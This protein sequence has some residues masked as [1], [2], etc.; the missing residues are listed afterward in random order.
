[1]EKKYKNVFWFLIDGLRPDFLHLDADSETCNFIDK[2]LLKGTVFN[3]VVTA[4]GGTFTSMHSIF[5]SLLPSFNGV[6]GWEK[7]AL[8]NFNEEIFTITDYFQ[9]AGYETFRYDDA[10]LSRDCPMNGFK[11]W[12]GSG[13]QT[14]KILDHTDLTKTERRNRFIEDVNTYAAN[15]FVYHHIALLHDL[16]GRMG[17][18]WTSEGYARD[19]KVT[20]KEFE[21]LYHEYVISEED[22]VIISADHGVLLD[23][24]YVHDNRKNKGRQYE[25]SVVSFFALI[26]QNVP[27]QILSNPISALDEAPTLLH[28]ALE[29][30][31][32]GQGRD[33]YNYIYKGE[34]QKAIYFR[35]T[36][37]LWG[38]PGLEN[39]L[40]SDLYYL[41]DGKWKY[42]YGDRDPRC[43]W[44]I[45][46]EED[47]DYQVNRKDQY[48][49]LR[50]K[51]YQM[52]RSKFDAAKDFQYRPAPGLNK[53]DLKKEF[54][55]I[56][57]VDD[58]DVDTVESVLDMSG[59]YYE[60]IMTRSDVTERFKDHYKVHL[61]DTLNEPAI[62]NCCQGEWLV[63]LSKNGEYSEYFLS[64]LYRYIQH[65]RKTNVKIIGEHYI[66]V[67]R[68]EAENFN[69]VELYETKQVRTIR[70]VHDEA[71]KFKYILFGCGEVGKEAVD[72][73][74]QANV[75]C[76]VDNNPTL[77][78]KD[79]RGKP[80][81]SFEKLKE[82][83]S[84]YRL[85]ITTRAPFVREI[86]AQLEREGIHNYFLLEERFR[87]NPATCW[88]SG[89][90][91]VR[92]DHQT[93]E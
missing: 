79:V 6:T 7:R 42:V 70:Y 4:G 38:L 13:Y 5:T 71:A 59:P 12:E 37:S 30:S 36:G 57:R 58:M 55:I 72:Y 76:F 32:P 64:D 43:E 1:V 34:Y 90:D 26:G 61:A 56:L 86:S 28:M 68:Q 33:Q 67:R 46:L 93:L 40:T 85:V 8:R 49:E 80:V 92:P 2:C 81:I 65:H 16:S 60:V 45:D 11:H 87:G 91:V 50:E 66:A 24:D 48:P 47:G 27:V 82:I 21:K 19:I 75:F 10:D 29:E 20:A 63:Y 89:Y 54:S 25:E 39:G 9:L 51:Y 17:T 77:V 23:K 14:T 74:G 15:K 41:R 78:G 62:R 52:I 69:G 31:M 88:E 3:H 35:E 18:F 83:H 84:G 53:A 22:L 73:F 44:L